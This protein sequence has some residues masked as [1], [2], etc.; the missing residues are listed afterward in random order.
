MN[1]INRSKVM[2]SL[3]VVGGL[4]DQGS[5]LVEEMSSLPSG[6]L[7]LLFFSLLLKQNILLKPNSISSLICPQNKAKFNRWQQKHYP[8]FETWQR[9]K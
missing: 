3:D 1:F 7:S 2:M 6:S 9:T 5:M 8:G 4:L